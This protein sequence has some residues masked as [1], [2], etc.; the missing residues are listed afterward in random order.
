[1]RECKHPTCGD[2]CRRPKKERKI[3]R[4]KQ[5][6]P[7]KSSRKKIKKISKTRGELLKIY[8]PLSA[9]YKIDNPLCKI[10]SPDCT[11]FTQGVHH[12]KGKIGELLI[13]ATFFMPACNSCNDYVET[14]DAWARQKGFKLSR[15]Q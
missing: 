9:Q 12:K 13:D 11:M 1:M 4:L 2:T 7:I 3:Y 15:V 8:K 5:R 14:H 6:T 10:N